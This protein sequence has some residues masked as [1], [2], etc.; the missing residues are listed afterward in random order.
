MKKKR[1]AEYDFTL[2]SAAL[3]VSASSTGSLL[4]KDGI[5]AVRKGSQMCKDIKNKQQ[6]RNLNRFGIKKDIARCIKVVSH[7]T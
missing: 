2:L 6:K 7:T 1:A 5:T 3:P 4:F